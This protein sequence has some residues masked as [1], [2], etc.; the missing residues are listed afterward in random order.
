M[1]EGILE[2]RRRSTETNRILVRCADEDLGEWQV[3][4]E[5]GQRARGLQSLRLSSPILV[6]LFDFFLHL[7]SRNA[8]YNVGPAFRGTVGFTAF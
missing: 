5:E 7:L 8:G 3:V 2:A 1:S 4:L 6:I